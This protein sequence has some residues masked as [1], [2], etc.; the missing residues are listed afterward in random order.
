VFSFW[1]E[2]AFGDTILTASRHCRDS[3]YKSE[4]YFTLSIIDNF[5]INAERMTAKGYGETKPIATNKT[6]EGRKDN[7]RVEAILNCG[8]K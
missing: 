8:G 3:F 7:R 6:A 1:V 4:K 2:F 5:G